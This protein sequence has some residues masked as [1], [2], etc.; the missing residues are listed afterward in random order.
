MR[1]LLD[2][3]IVQN[4]ANFRGSEMKAGL[5]ATGVQVTRL[6]DT[7]TPAFPRGLLTNGLEMQ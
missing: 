1:I 2:F 6:L 3:S 4:K 7:D 5:C